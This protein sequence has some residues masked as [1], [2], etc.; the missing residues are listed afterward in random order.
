MLSKWRLNDHDSCDSPVDES[1][2]AGC[3][4]AKI[5]VTVSEMIGGHLFI[6][7]SVPRAWP[8]WFMPILLVHQATKGIIVLSGKKNSFCCHLLW[9]ILLFKYWKPEIYPLVV[10]WT[11]CCRGLKGEYAKVV[12]WKCWLFT[13]CG[14]QREYS[15][16]GAL[17][18]LMV[19]I[20]SSSLAHTTVDS[21]IPLLASLLYISGYFNRKK[22]T[23]RTGSNQNLD[24]PLDLDPIVE[25][26]IRYTL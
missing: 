2:E 26:G 14:W 13:V 8:G 25:W 22:S 5:G 4:S 17:P 6:W 23:R 10:I 7:L 20:Q 18:N 21:P 11:Y 9:Y 1:H 12:L 24:L 15:Q 3:Y 19:K 16:F